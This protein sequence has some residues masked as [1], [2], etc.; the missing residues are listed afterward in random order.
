MPDSDDC[1]F[2]SL[3]FVVNNIMISLCIQGPVA[4]QFVHKVDTLKAQALRF[5]LTIVI[6]YQSSLLIHFHV[7][8]ITLHMSI[9]HVIEFDLVLIHNI[10]HF[11]HEILIIT[12][13]L[14]VLSF[15]VLLIMIILIKAQIRA[16][17]VFVIGV[18]F[19]V[20][21]QIIGVHFIPLARIH[22]V[23]IVFVQFILVIIPHKLDRLD[24]IMNKHISIDICS[25]SAILLVAMM[26]V[27]M[28]HNRI[29]CK[30]DLDRF[31]VVGELAGLLNVEIRPQFLVESLRQIR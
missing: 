16:D 6:H 29:L 20:F 8:V 1:V 5:N 12:A 15:A 28:S 19:I 18:Y 31:R 4:Q 25:I 2:L 24:D 17:I 9:Q 22:I 7:I 13:I 11:L 21:S 10:H 23:C 30:L 14:T 3:S 27:I 26:I